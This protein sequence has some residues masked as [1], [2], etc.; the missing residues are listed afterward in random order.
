MTASRNRHAAAAG[1]FH[2]LFWCALG[3]MAC[4]ITLAVIQHVGTSGNGA[5]VAA[6]LVTLAAMTSLVIADWAYI[7]RLTRFSSD[8]KWLTY[9]RSA[10]VGTIVTLAGLI[11]M[12]IGAVM[13]S[14]FAPLD[15]SAGVSVG[16]RCV[17][18][19]A[20]V[21]AIGIFL[22]YIRISQMC[23]TCARVYRSRVLQRSAGHV[24]R[25]FWAL[26]GAAAATG[27]LFLLVGGLAAP[28]LLARLLDVVTI[29]VQ[30]FGLY[31]LVVHLILLIR[32]AGV[33]DIAATEEGS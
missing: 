7:S 16:S 21:A 2:G 11:G 33:L 6:F 17:L 22:V 9:S 14:V 26:L 27:T 3:K 20:A 8:P 32:T 19:A 23:A 15:W 30:G 5:V 10:G 25:C 18:T 24:L 1:S 28:G 31:C 4:A 13:L 29:A 12:F